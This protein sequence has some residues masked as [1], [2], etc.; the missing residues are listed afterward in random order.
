MEAYQERVVVEKRELDE[1]LRKLEDFIFR[2]GGKW[3]DVPDAERLRMTKQYCHM[4]DY[5]RILGERIAAFTR[6]GE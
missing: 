5:S 6:K 2:S 4:S 3:F 1:K